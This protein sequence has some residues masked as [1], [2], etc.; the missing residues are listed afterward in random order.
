M[1]TMTIGKLAKRAKIKIETIRYYEQRGLMPPPNRRNSGYREYSQSDIDRLRF[2]KS[3][4]DLGFSLKEVIELLSLKTGQDTTCGDIKTF[5]Q[6]KVD[7]I[8]KK[9]SSLK[10]IKNALEILND[11]CKKRNAPVSD[12]PILEALESDS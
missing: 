3:T 12:C 10:K 2:I 9:I 8:E 1:E 6:N 11:Q 4:K 7:E 5:V